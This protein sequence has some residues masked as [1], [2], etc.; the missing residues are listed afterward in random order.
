MSGIN[1]AL[2][3]AGFTLIELLVVIAIIAVLVALLLPAVQQAREAARRSQCKNNLK[4]IGLAMHNYHDV[5]NQFAIDVGW[6]TGNPDSRKAAFSDKVFLLPFL[7]QAPIYNQINWN[8]R[9]WDQGGWGGNDNINALSVNLP[10]FLCPSNP[11]QAKNGARANSNYAIN[12]GTMP[13]PGANQTH[14]GMSSFVGYGFNSDAP[15]TAAAVSDGLS[16]TALYSEILPDPGIGYIQGA[17]S[18]DWITCTDPVS[19]RLNCNTATSLSGREVK[20]SSWS[21]SWGA[22]G[23][24]YT[25][26]M[27]PNETTCYNLNNYTDWTNNT[28]TSAASKHVGGVQVL[29][30]DGSVHFITNSVD[31]PTWLGMGTRNMGETI[32]VNF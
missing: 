28:L 19:C 11:Y 10:V 17:T 6:A 23:S 26:V 27:A 32:A 9:P 8:G 21:W 22:F 14:N 24:G 30:G 25:H 29:Y 18:R 2:R 15:V 31:W 3:R 16:Q 20:G 7:D 5:Y 4:Q 13:P 12:I 1:R